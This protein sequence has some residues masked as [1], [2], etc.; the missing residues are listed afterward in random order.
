MSTRGAEAANIYKVRTRKGAAVFDR[1]DA[2]ESSRYG[3]HAL[4]RCVYY[5]HA[6]SQDYIPSENERARACSEDSGQV[7]PYC[8]G[9]AVVY[10]IVS[11][12]DGCAFVSL[13]RDLLNSGYR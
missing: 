13:V 1:P 3:N 10:D 9:F 12:A 11:R 2:R 5:H 6:Y 7:R 8:I 4:L